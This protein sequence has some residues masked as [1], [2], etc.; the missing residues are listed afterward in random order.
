M[1]SLIIE[2]NIKLFFTKR[3]ISLILCEFVL[4]NA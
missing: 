3:K 1:V 2:E 4:K